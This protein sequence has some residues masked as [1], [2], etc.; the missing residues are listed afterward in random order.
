MYVCTYVMPN[1]IIMDHDFFILMFMYMYVC[2]PVS[3]QLSNRVI[4][5]ISCGGM[6]AYVGE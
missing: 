1:S 6:I 5:N 3:M 2:V 4:R